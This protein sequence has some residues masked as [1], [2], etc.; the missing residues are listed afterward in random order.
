MRWRSSSGT[1]DIGGVVGRPHVV[2][3]VVL[4]CR[5]ASAA[6]DERKQVAGAAG[7]SNVNDQH[8]DEPN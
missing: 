5:C 6:R 1:H 3:T 7:P 4:R 2:K 8:D